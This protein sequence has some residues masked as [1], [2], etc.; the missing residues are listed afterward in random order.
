MN[1]F[2]ALILGLVQGLTEFIPVSSSGHL[3]LVPWFLGWPSP[4]LAFDTVLH[5]G[6]LAAILAVFWRDLIA[7][8]LALIDGVR[9]RSLATAQSKMAAALVIA[10]VPAALLGYFGQKLFEDLFSAPEWVAAFLLG[11]AV[12]LLA[13]ERL[14][15]KARSLEQ[16]GARSALLIG[17][18]Q[19]LAIAPGLSRSGA[20]ISAGRFLGLPRA[21]AARF[22]FLLAA[23]II[24][25]AGGLQVVK[26]AGTG[27]LSQ[28]AGLL[29]IGF[30][31]ALASGY[32][33][34]RF[35]LKYLQ[36]HSLAPF[37]LYCAG[38]GLLT[39][40]AWLVR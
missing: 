25:G 35:L 22:S 5:L 16:V 17:L 4:G 20:T 7:L 32:L 39:L 10:T 33:V 14:V 24:A 29:L 23:P 15:G 12:L 13:S 6:T 8:A 19:G 38:L 27:A 2:Q 28:N 18:F 21:D 26:L 37:A 3:V 30:V 36:Q 34:I 9:R 1:L 40:V 11:T 31:T